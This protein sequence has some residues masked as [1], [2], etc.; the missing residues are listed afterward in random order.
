MRGLR[1]QKLKRKLTKRRKT[2]SQSDMAADRM[3]SIEKTFVVSFSFDL[4]KAFGIPKL[5]TSVA[6]KRN[7]H[8]YNFGCQEFSKNIS[9]MFVWPETEGS[10]GAQEISSC[11]IKYIKT[12]AANFEKNNNIF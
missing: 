1:L 2:G 8:I 5:T 7:L 12:Y 3:A 6:Y 4:V 10:R 9:H 11:L